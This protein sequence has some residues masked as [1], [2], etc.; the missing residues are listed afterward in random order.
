MQVGGK[1]HVLGL[2]GRENILARNSVFVVLKKDSYRH[3]HTCK[4]V[5]SA[6]LCATVK[7]LSEAS[8]RIHFYGAA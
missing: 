5:P 2:A 6:R 8:M 7:V 3:F 1:I 4:C